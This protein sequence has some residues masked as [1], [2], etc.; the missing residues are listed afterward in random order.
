M[1]VIRRWPWLLVALAV[2]LAGCGGG[3]KKHSSTAP[4][5][6]APASEAPA[7]AGGIPQIV[8]RVD[9]RL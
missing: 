5:A 4:A 8:D 3:S 9:L 6:A 1:G 7:L 2:G